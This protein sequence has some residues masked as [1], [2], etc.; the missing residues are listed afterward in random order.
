MDPILV[1][2]IGVIV[3]K[4]NG[5]SMILG[6]VAMRLEGKVA[7]VTGSARGIGST[8]AKVF[9]DQGAKV[10]LADLLIVDGERTAQSI[11][12][13]NRQAIFMF[14]DVTVEASWQSCINSI[15]EKLGGLDVLVNNAGVGSR[16]GLEKLSQDEWQYTLDVNAKGPYLGINQVVKAMEANGGGSIVNI[17]SIAAMV[18]GET[19]V[20]YRA[21]KGALRA[22]TKAMAVRWASKGIR[23]NSIHPGD[24]ITPLNQSFLNNER[25]LKKR[26]NLVPLG[27]LGTPQ[28]VAFLALYL[29]SDESS[30]ITG[31]EV[32]I[33]GGR[34]AN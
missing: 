29:A 21:S 3:S 18:G 20:A 24:V 17:S 22:L 27:R 26:I 23:I 15:L 34:I 6:R 2:W 11:R 30:Y 8:I 7:L 33:D 32:I 16:I 9:A 4:E 12:N 10:V 13:S 5:H 31:S 14:L 1:S 28:D 19:S 25:E